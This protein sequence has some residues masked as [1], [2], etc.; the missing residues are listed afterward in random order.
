MHR[1]G[2]EGGQPGVDGQPG[3]PFQGRYSCFTT[4]STM[5]VTSSL[6]LYLLRSVGVTHA[7]RCTDG[8][9]PCPSLF[10]HSAV[11]ATAAHP[12][13]YQPWQVSA[14]R[15]GTGSGFIICTQRR[16]LLT[17]SHVVGHVTC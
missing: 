7:F 2:G 14:Q 13:Y 10:A 1:V 12:N 17:N 3:L 8:L 16:H 4:H 6:L 15:A 11:F 9:L 5:D